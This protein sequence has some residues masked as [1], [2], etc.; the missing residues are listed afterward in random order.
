MNSGVKQLALSEVL[1]PSEMDRLYSEALR[2]AARN[3][4][5]LYRESSLLVTDLLPPD[6]ARGKD[7]LLL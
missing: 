4:V 3:H 1:P 6:V 7:V 5:Q 2:V